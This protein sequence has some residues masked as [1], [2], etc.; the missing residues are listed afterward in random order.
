MTGGSS[1]QGDGVAH[2][3]SWAVQLCLEIADG[4]VSQL[5]LTIL[6]EDRVAIQQCARRNA[7]EVGGNDAIQLDPFSSLDL[8]PENTFQ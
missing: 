7:Y 4:K 6:I 8:F 2:D 3:E 5:P 1:V